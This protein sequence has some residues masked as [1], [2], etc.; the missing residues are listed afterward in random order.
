MKENRVMQYPLVDSMR[1]VEEN[2]SYCLSIHWLKTLK[3]GV[4]LFKSI[5][6]ARKIDGEEKGTSHWEKAIINERT[7]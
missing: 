6:E 2:G 5:A 1:I 4:Y 7:S 3:Y